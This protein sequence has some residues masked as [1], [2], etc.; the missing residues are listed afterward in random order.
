MIVAA[1][2]HAFT[3]VGYRRTNPGTPGERIE[4]IRQ[5]D[6]KGPYKLIRNFMHDPHGQWEWLFVPLPTKV[7][8]P[9][10]TAEA[11][12]RR[13]LIETASSST[14]K[15]AQD[16][17]RGVQGD[18]KEIAFRS[19]VIRSNQF[20]ATLGARGYTDEIA[21]LYRRMQMPRWIW[22]VEAILRRERAARE[23]AVLAE[24]VIDA[25]DHSRDLHVLAWRIPGELWSWRPDDDHTATRPVAECELVASVAGYAL[26]R[27]YPAQ[28]A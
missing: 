20:K 3:L 1:G 24:A 6:E 11:L 15:T 2:V 4:F 21:A 16:L 12:G 5:D 26:A 9:G 28:P 18:V 7:F 25:T 23:R 22:V 8:L 27:P 17:A 13:R 14:H 19:T 10:E